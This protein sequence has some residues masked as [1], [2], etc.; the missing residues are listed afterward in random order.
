MTHPAEHRILAAKLQEFLIENKWISRTP[1]SFYV[2]H[3]WSKIVRELN[4]EIRLY[5]FPDGDRSVL[6]VAII[7]EYNGCPAEVRV[8]LPTYSITENLVLWIPKLI[9]SSKALE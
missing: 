7:Q 3:R 9:E 5:L 8:T 6:E 1:G 4:I 2:T